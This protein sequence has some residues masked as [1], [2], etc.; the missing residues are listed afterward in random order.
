MKNYPL[1]IIVFLENS[2]YYS[3]GHH[4]KQLFCDEVNSEYDADISPAR[5]RH[6]WMRCRPALPIE[7]E[8]YGKVTFLV[9]SKQGKRGVFPVTIID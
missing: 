5:V 1:E 6:T 7:R 2:G 3:K 8:E 4:D 9:E